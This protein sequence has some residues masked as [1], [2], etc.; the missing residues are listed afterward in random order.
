MTNSAA[1]FANISKRRSVCARRSSHESVRATKT[2]VSSFS[3]PLT[4]VSSSLSIAVVPPSSQT[5]STSHSSQLSSAP[6]N[7][8]SQSRISE[9]PSNIPIAP[10]TI[11][12]P[13]RASSVA[14]SP[15]CPPLSFAYFWYVAG[16]CGLPGIELGSRAFGPFDDLYGL[17]A[18]Y[19]G[20]FGN[21]CAYR[22]RNRTMVF[23]SATLRLVSSLLIREY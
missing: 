10:S 22:Y 4:V 17:C 8:H 21:R 5:V 1:N 19:C 7:P 11:L 20:T 13:S 12:L 3:V 23:A 6:L 15:S 2:T 9:S 16:N 18:R 14:P